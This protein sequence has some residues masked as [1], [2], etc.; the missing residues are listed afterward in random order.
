MSNP[1]LLESKS[2][3]HVAY[4]TR[5][6]EATYDFY[7]HKLGMR[8]LRTENHRQG[9]GHFRHFFFGMGSGEAIA[10][11]YLENVGE[12]PEYKTEISTG[13]GLPPWANH[14]AFRLDTMEELEAMTKRMHER[15][16]ENIIQ[17]DH[18]WCTSIYTL[19]PNGIMVEYCVTTDAKGFEQSEEEALRLLRQPSSEFAEEER[20]EESIGKL[21]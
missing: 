18:G 3:H 8:L 20:K 5:D 15:G 11:F 13:L 12:D 17:I 1:N 2:V 21:V 6:V 10:F 19:D 7:T 9:D 14:I 16:I 4:T